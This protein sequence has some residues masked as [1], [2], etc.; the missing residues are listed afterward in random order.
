MKEI[1][2]TTGGS[3]RVSDEDFDFLSQW[4]W[5]RNTNGYIYRHK[6]F[7]KGVKVINTMHTLIFER[8]GC[9]GSPDHKDRDKLN[10]QRENLREASGTENQ[11]N[12]GVQTNNTSG[13]KGVSRHRGKWRAVIAR[14]K[15]QFHLGYFSTPEQAA[16]AYNKAALRMYGEFAFLNTVNT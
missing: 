11:A 5:S 1:S 7:P 12:K 13:Y 3:A 6:Y 10:N 9:L 4:N 2:L 14:K 16:L 15:V 8:M